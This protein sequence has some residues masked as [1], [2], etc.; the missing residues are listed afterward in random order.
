MTPIQ[1]VFPEVEDLPP[2]FPRLRQWL[3]NLPAFFADTQLEAR[4]RTYY[5]RKDRTIDILSKAWESVAPRAGRWVR[6]LA[7]CAPLML[8]FSGRGG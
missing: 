3:Q 6:R 8:R 5:L 2:L 1:R 4:F 7:G